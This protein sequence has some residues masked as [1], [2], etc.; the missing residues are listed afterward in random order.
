MGH[1]GKTV[2]QNVVSGSEITDGTVTGADLAS[3]IAIT[4]TSNIGVGTT[5]PAHNLEIK[6][7]LSNISLDITKCCLIPEFS[8]SMIFF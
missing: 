1:V 7:S 6:D 2:T 4:T 3:D 5:N 8:F